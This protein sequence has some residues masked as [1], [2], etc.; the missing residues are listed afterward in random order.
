MDCTIR[1]DGSVALSE[2]N[3]T[4]YSIPRI[5]R[6]TSNRRERD[7]RKRSILRR[8]ICPMMLD[9]GGGQ[10]GNAGNRY[11]I[12]ARKEIEPTERRIVPGSEV[13]H[14]LHSA[15]D[16]ARLFHRQFLCR[17]SLPNVLLRPYTYTLRSSSVQRRNRPGPCRIIYHVCSI[18]RPEGTSTVT[19]RRKFFESYRQQRS[20]LI[21]KHK[22]KG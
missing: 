18:D 11:A 1:R 16:N 15:A 12:P 17:L 7:R 14:C 4:L 2:R 5:R 3:E 6:Q 10:R 19:F 22:P 20:I 21:V 13:V 9:G 8:P